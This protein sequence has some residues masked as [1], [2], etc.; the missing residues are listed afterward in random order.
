M[1]SF[2]RRLLLL[3]FLIVSVSASYGHHRDTLDT[4]G[5]E[6]IENRGQWDSQVLFHTRLSCGGLF[7]EKH[8]F[9]YVTIDPQQLEAFYHH[10][11]HPSEPYVSDGT[12]NAAAYKVHFLNA[13]PEVR[14]MGHHATPDYVNYFI[15]NDPSRWA[16]N[17]RKYEE[18][19]YDELYKGIDLQYYQ[20]NHL[21]YEFTVDPGVSPSQ[22]KMKYEG[23][24][25]LSIVRNHL[26]INT[27]VSQIIELKPIAYQLSPNG[28]TVWVSCN[29]RLNKNILSFEV[30][31][32]D[33][34]RPL[35]ID[36][37]LVF[38]SFSGSTADNWGYSATYDNYGNLYAGGNVF[39]IGYPTTTG[40]FQIKYGGGDCDISISKF[41]SDGA[42]LQYSTY[43]GGAGVDIPHSMVVN[44][45]DELYILGT[46]G[47]DNFPTT[48]DAYQR[49]FKGGT[50][51]TL[52]SALHYRSGSDLVV[53]KLNSAGT[54]LLGSTYLGGTGNDGLNVASNLKVNYADEVRG[55]ILV[56]NHSNVYVV[57][58]TQSRN[59]PTTSKAFQR[60]FGGGNQDGCIFKMNNNLSNLVW[61]SYL[62]G[63]ND[64]AAY[65]VFLG[66]DN[67]I[68]VCGGTLS[69]NLPTTSNAY[70][71]TIASN[72]VDGFISRISNDGNT[73]INCTYLGFTGYDQTYLI[74]GDRQGFPY[75]FG[76]TNATGD[77][78]IKNVSWYV[79]SG[80]Q[81]LTKL[82]HELDKI[83]WSTAFGTGRGGPDLSP[84]ALLIDLCHNIYMSGWGSRNLNNFG[85]T[86][87]LPVTQDAFQHTT[88]NNDYYFIC[89][90]DN[91]SRLVY[92]TYFGSPNADEH[93]DGGTSRFDKKGKI[94]QAVCAGC[95]GISNFPTTAGAWSRRNRSTNCNIG[96]IKFDFNLP[97]V[98]ADF[99]MP[100]TI[101]AP[102]EIEFENTSQSIS[103]NSTEYIWD[104]GDGTNSKEKNPKHLFTKSGTYDVSLIVNDLTS[105]NFGDT[106]TKSLVVLS[107]SYEKLP[108][109]GC[110]KEGQV[111]IGIPPSGNEDIRYR[112][113]PSTG[114][115]NPNLSNPNASPTSTTTYKLFITDGNC[116]DT[117]EQTVYIDDITIDMPEHLYVCLGDSILLDPVIEGLHPKVTWSL[118]PT[119]SPRIND[120][121]SSS[122]RVAPTER[123][124]YY[125]QVISDYCKDFANVTVDVVVLELNMPEQYA[126]CDD[127]ATTL[128]VEVNSNKPQNYTYDWQPSD[129]IISGGNTNSPT[130]APRQTTRYRVT[131]TSD[132]GCTASTE[133]EVIITSFTPADFN[134]WCDP[135]TVF[136]GEST[137][138]HATTIDGYQYSWSPSQGLENPNQANTLATPQRT[139]CYTVTVT[140]LN[141]CRKQDTACVKVK[142]VI[143]KEPFIFVP[144]AFTPNGDGKNDVFYVRGN[145]F[146]LSFILRIYDRWGEKV[147]ESENIEDGWDGTFR[148][149]IC[150]PGIYDFYLEATCHGKQRFIKKGNITLIR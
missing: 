1:K 25:S 102:Y 125:M 37:E 130:V 96:L 146:L 112:W 149:K 16:S 115:D 120:E 52:T 103:D 139:M 66:V 43:I 50:N 129:G 42:F 67:S 132:M 138:L 62:G 141:G 24:K 87:G 36:P 145:E 59:F 122:V 76:Q 144:N 94:Y 34:E 97:S 104:F 124:T 15:G 38:S 111:Q 118:S 84:S 31:A 136:E 79:Y 58:C 143:C 117:M 133:T 119:M 121:E 81:F 89:L 21:K 69:S 77:K 131:V 22:I 33:T 90:D 44:E 13:N 134:A 106:V 71:R 73:I 150:Q 4:K 142:E 2:M 30:G 110:C 9:T 55:E 46:T 126:I 12:M 47:S 27:D 39:A 83:L 147:F 29:Y 40:A 19:F 80:G 17:V 93:V 51:Y 128:L 113:Q 3:F 95:G 105:C 114:L 109:L 127:G 5:V 49:A 107:N 82:S 72:G 23:V 10:K 135:D 65:S 63:N 101:C 6:F 8:T 148:G 116:V 68:Y 137:N 61:G 91:V 99:I 70:Q 7:L 26:F 11:K 123:T 74:K 28:D 20:K 98:I 35:V 57:S 53:V 85:G 86:S 14:I 54:A 32:Y 45:N 48:S 100:N 78:W 92:A 75:V 88:D 60:Q 140:D 41:D 108:D 18:V 56:D 64:D